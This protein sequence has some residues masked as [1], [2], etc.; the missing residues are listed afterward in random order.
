MGS[1]DEIKIGV[2]EL[3][4]LPCNQR[5]G[6]HQAPGPQS[7]CWPLGGL[8]LGCSQGPHHQQACHAHQWRQPVRLQMV[9]PFWAPWH[10]LWWCAP[11]LALGAALEPAN[12]LAILLRAVEV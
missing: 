7:R 6:Y 3:R 5:Q 11:A 10:T 9:E 4:G 8:L 2:D 1:D 12:A